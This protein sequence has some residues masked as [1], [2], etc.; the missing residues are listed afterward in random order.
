MPNNFYI[1]PGFTSDWE[2]E[3]SHGEHLPAFTSYCRMQQHLSMLY[4][5]SKALAVSS[6]YQQ[7]HYQPLQSFAKTTNACWSSTSFH[8]LQIGLIYSLPAIT[9]LCKTQ[10]A[11]WSSSLHHPLWDKI[12]AS[13]ISIPLQ[14]ITEHKQCFPKLALTETLQA[15][16]SISGKQTVLAKV[17]SVFKNCCTAQTSVGKVLSAFTSF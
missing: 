1:L 17:L 16:T 9:S 7:T 5:P 2:T 8:Q 15:F 12:F 13:Q 6:L 14:D 10:R 4:Q 11:C 3:P